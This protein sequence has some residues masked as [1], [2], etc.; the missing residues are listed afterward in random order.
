MNLILVDG[1]DFVSETTVVLRD[2]RF[3]HVTQIHRAQL[4]DELRVG[5]IDGLMGTA[6]VTRIDESEIE[7][8]V[9]LHREPP[10]PLNL[11]L[12]L[13]L[14]RPKF[15]AKV[16]QTVTSL[17]VKEIYLINSYRVEKVYWSCQQIT[18]EEIRRACLLGLEQAKDTKL[19]RVHLR[20]LFKPFVEDEL[21]S[22]I[23]GAEALVA[24]PVAEVECPRGITERPIAL[25]I[26]P[27]GG[28]IDYEIEKLNRAGFRSVRLTSRILKVETAVATLIGRLT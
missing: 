4:Q 24:H 13:A 20:P 22:L 12:F 14:P 21:P 18:P 23:N 28:F 3:N 25:A 26:G 19:P 5:R 7:L 11:T 2:R 6:L 9:N 17:G 10:P 16:L 27:E 15:L 8:S 1:H